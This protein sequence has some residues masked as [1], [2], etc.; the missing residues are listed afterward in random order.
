MGDLRGVY[1]SEDVHKILKMAAAEK[2]VTV[3]QLAEKIIKNGIKQ[4]GIDNE[5][6]QNKEKNN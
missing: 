2:G 1:V 5:K 6:N 3:K 4:D